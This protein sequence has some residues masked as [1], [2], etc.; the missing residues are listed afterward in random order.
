MNRN[1]KGGSCAKNKPTM[2][3]L[4][5]LHIVLFH[6]PIYKIKMDLPDYFSRKSPLTFEVIGIL[7]HRSQ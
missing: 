2:D 5:A 6:V 3:F 1:D 7:Q 4:Q